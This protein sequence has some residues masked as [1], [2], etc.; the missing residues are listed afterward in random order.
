MLPS[1]SYT[2]MSSESP[3][4][5]TSSNNR[6]GHRGVLSST[7]KSQTRLDEDSPAP[8][9]AVDKPH[10]S[11]HLEDSKEENV[12]NWMG[13]GFYLSACQDVRESRKQVALSPRLGMGHMT[14][15]SYMRVTEWLDF[16]QKD[17]V[18]VLLDLG[19]GTDEPDICTKIPSRFISCASLA[20]G[21]N[22]RVFIEAQRQRM[23]VESPNLC[24]RFRQ[25]QV[26]DH[27]TSAF[28]SL[29][30]DINTMQ[31]KTEVRNGGEK[32]VDG[33]P[34]GKPLVT[35][36]KRKRI[37]QLLRK[38][39][40][41]T[42]MH[43]PQA[44]QNASTCKTNEDHPPAVDVEKHITTR[45]GLSE[46]IALVPLKEELLPSGKDATTGSQPSPS[47]TASKTWTLPFL[48][49]KQAH[50]PFA[51]EMPM[52]DRPRKEP[53]LLLAHTLKRVS[54]LNGKPT[55][56][57]EMEEIQSFEDESS[58]G[59][60]LES[61]SDVLVTRTNSCQSDSSG[62]LEDPSEPLPLQVLSLPGNLRFSCI[63]HDNQGFLRHRK[64]STQLTSQ[65]SL[66]HP[67]DP[68]ANLFR[69]DGSNVLSLPYLS[70]EHTFQGE[71]I[72]YSINEED[73]L[74]ENF[75][76]QSEGAASE[77]VREMEEEMMMQD[78]R[79][80]LEKEDSSAQY[81]DSCSHSD[82]L[83]QANSNP[84]ERN[85][86]S[87]LSGLERGIGSASNTESCLTS[88]GLSN[89]QNF[90]EGKASE[91]PLTKEE[92][93][94]V[95]VENDLE[96]IAQC[97]EGKWCDVM[98]HRMLDSPVPATDVV[99]DASNSC[100]PDVDLNSPGG[101]WPLDVARVSN[102]EHDIMTSHHEINV[103]S[104]S[105]LQDS[106]SYCFEK[107]LGSLNRLSASTELDQD[108][109]V[110]GFEMNTNSYK[111][112]TVQM[113]SRLMSNITLVE[114]PIKAQSV[115]FTSTVSLCSKGEHFITSA[116]GASKEENKQVKEASIQ[117]DQRQTKRGTLPLFHILP[118][119]HGHGHLV[120][121]AS[122]D[123]G[124]Y[125]TYRSY[126]QEPLSSWCAP[127]RSHC[128]PMSSHHCCLLWSF[129]FAPSCKHPVGCCSSHTTTELQL[130]KTLKL[131][132]DS[133]VRN[134][135]SCTVHEI[136]VMKNSCQKFRERLDEIEQHLIEQEAACSSAM[137]DEGREERRR[138]QVL[139]Q[140]VR[141]E[142]TELECQ[143]Q[144]RARQ[145][146]E[147]ILVQLDQL[148]EE[149]SNLCAELEI[150][151]WREERRAQ[152]E[153]PSPNAAASTVAFVPRARC[154]KGISHRPPQRSATVPSSP[155][156][157]LQRKTELLASPLATSKTNSIADPKELHTSKK[158][159]KGP[160]PKKI[161]LKAFLQ[162][163]KK[164]FRN[165]FSNDTSEGRD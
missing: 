113:P 107:R 83:D 114:G 81:C 9:P 141:R 125:G 37:G 135:S 27:V 129:P 109:H 152:N 73:D 75:S 41:Q 19:F 103:I 123:T 69:A 61:T 5:G 161:D 6:T 158:E 3:H 1:R 68:I 40:R 122:L 28:S 20:K 10:S 126:C 154:S 53:N 72:F 146:K 56:S 39:S 32:R 110:T 88:I 112:V 90:E 24:G 87:Y 92:I 70:R 118:S 11:P 155:S 104:K 25:L 147:G 86:G 101:P 132:Q 47:S 46:N 119:F 85:C 57:F 78:R 133:A 58:W 105:P 45:T 94:D 66:P 130:L 149:Q 134:V 95:Y 151:A 42:T 136:E 43:G 60:P 48:P 145:V 71:E 31:Q 65:D 150:S 93:G 148:L 96:C 15:Q 116:L 89:G 64:E 99:S 49:V 76:D 44:Y 35:L 140:A 67:E 33:I 102:N 97:V 165:S 16:W 121:S 62:F 79:G 4:P 138:L 144:E 117:T 131:L 124:L 160:S 21:I 59:N 115:D 34:K 52:K 111:S 143:L 36:A 30:S 55:D 157:C 38:V 120:K 51:P 14:V 82:G 12:R 142:L 159:A 29:L 7:R 2:E 139:R 74:P 23:D 8:K 127:H 77:T 163:L 91:K 156:A 50:L 100:K 128:C 98:A 106:S 80:Q 162:N 13:S 18:E 164:S 63:S 17:P 108:E 84:S 54:G 22:I 26:L 153:P 137:S